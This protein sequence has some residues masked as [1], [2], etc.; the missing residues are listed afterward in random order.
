MR[1]PARIFASARGRRTTIILLV[2]LVVLF[3][4][5]SVLV[6]RNMPWLS[7][8][9]A[10][11]RWIRSF[12]LLAPVAFVVVQAGQVLIAPIPGH[13]LGVVSGYLFGT[14]WGTVFSLTGATIGTALAMGLSRRYGRRFAESAIDSEAL[15]QFD[16]LARR[17]GLLA[18]FLVFLLPGLPD[19]V[20]CFAAGLTDLRISHLIAVSVVGRLPGYLVLNFVGAELAADRIWLTVGIVAVLA[21]LSA[22]VYLRRRELLARLGVAIPE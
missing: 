19:D 2:G 6:D 3:G 7:D 18:L 12:G 5:A 16:D 13:V 14:I 10:M 11:R 8:P 21:A 22:V 20:V 9:A 1:R 15:A 17:H 4:L